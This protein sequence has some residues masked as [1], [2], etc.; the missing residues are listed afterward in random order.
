MHEG[1]FFLVLG[2][3]GVGVGG[4]YLV[5]SELCVVVRNQSMTSP[6]GRECVFALFL[7]CRPVKVSERSECV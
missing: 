7:E 2:R 4:C 6:L 5:R 3:G 1:I